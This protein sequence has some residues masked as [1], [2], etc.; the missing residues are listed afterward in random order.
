M[1]RRSTYLAMAT[2]LGLLLSAAEAALAHAFDPALLVLTEVSS[3]EYIQLWKVP[4]ANAHAMQP[5][6]PSACTPASRP[7]KQRLESLV[8]EVTT[9]RCGASLAGKPVGIAFSANARADALF[10]LTRPGT[11]PWQAVLRPESPYTMI[12]TEPTVRSVLADYFRLGVEHIAS[13]WDHL[14]FLLCLILIVGRRLRMLIVAAT[15]FTL[16]HTVTLVAASLDLIHLPQRP[17][18]A[19]VALSIVLLARE[20]VMDN[21]RSLTFRSP[22]LVAAAL[23]LVHGLG[24]AGALEEIGTPTGQLVAALFSFNIGVEVGQLGLIIAACTVGSGVQ[25]AWP[26]LRRAVDSRRIAFA[27]GAVSSSWLLQRLLAG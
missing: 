27:A 9:V 12:P 20:L 10:R 2:C 23:G 13:G 3:G 22:G 25:K 16:G 24:F 1:A 7:T 18:E 14:L 4:I 26:A 21:R 11:E 8:I 6:L 17:V 15:G 19:L 5:A